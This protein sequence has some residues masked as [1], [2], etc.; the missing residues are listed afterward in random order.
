[1]KIYI[2]SFLS[3]ISTIGNIGLV[4]LVVKFFPD[5]IL[6]KAASA[7]LLALQP[8][9][10]G[11]YIKRHYNID[12]RAPKDN[13][14][15]KQRWNGFAINF[16]FFI[17]TS[18]DVTIL[19]LMNDLKMVSVY[20][21]YYFAVD[22]ISVLIHSITWGIEP[23]I[24]QTYA[25]NDIDD[26][27]EK[28]NLY[29]FIIFCSIGI[30]FTLMALLITPFVSIYTDG[31]T[32]TNY[33]QPIFGM[34]LVLAEALYLLSLPHF[35]LANV[36]NKFKKMTVPAYMEAVIN[37][38]VS[39]ALIRPFGLVGIAIGTASGALCRMIFHV[40]LT[41]KIIPNRR[42]SIFYRKLL[43]FMIVTVAGMLIC[44]IAIPFETVTIT[45]WI[46]HAIVYGIIIVILYFSTSMIFFKREIRHLVNYIRRR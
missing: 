46:V 1:M 17:H 18:I 34:V 24:G 37:I 11:Y 26:L 38:A 32:D 30:L 16:A 33:Y 44:R 15:I 10:F 27:H 35:T 21:V 9:V 40:S 13:S 4:V 5:I 2:V 14:L 41:E 7:A 36:A 31:I 43:I 29:E 28:M 45:E 39:V 20:I 12:W 22:K 23:T 8:L 19:T 3:I 6:L 25:R 42:Q